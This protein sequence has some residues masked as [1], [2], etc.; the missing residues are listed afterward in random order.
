MQLD[1]ETMR[2]IAVGAS[3]AA[4]CLPC[5]K[6]NAEKAVEAGADHREVAEAIAI[7]K[8]VRQG[9]ASK[10]DRFISGMANIGASLEGIAGTDCECGVQH[11]VKE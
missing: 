4:N 10:M 1:E 9:A 7:G 8:M 6:T 11:T 5:L 3:V 2:L